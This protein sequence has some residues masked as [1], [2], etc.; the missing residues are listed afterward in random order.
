MDSRSKY[1]YELLDK[2]CEPTKLRHTVQELPERVSSTSSRI[3]AVADNTSVLPLPVLKE[4]VALRRLGITVRVKADRATAALLRRHISGIEPVDETDLSLSE[5]IEM[6]IIAGSPTW[7]AKVALGIADSL[8]SI[9]ALRALMRGIPVFADL[10]GCLTAFY[11]EK[12]S[13]PALTAIYDN[14]IQVLLTLGVRQLG[15]GDMLIEVPRFFE[16]D[17]RKTGTPVGPQDRR[18]EK[19][20]FITKRDV[21]RH[22][23]DVIHIASNT[24]VTDEAKDTAAR[25]N[26]RFVK[27]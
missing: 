22:Q 3:L 7:I 1:T 11:G 20:T 24:I 4:A 8:T 23:S 21:E 27:V 6:L 16:M 5:S 18:N 12:M 17:C 15:R 19:R 10:N 2:I 26:V 9:L 13:N 25:L 14:Y